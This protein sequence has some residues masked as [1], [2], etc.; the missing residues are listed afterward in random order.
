MQR[1]K[2]EIKKLKKNKKSEKKWMKSLESIGKWMKGKR[3]DIKKED[4]WERKIKKSLK[5]KRKK[6]WE[7]W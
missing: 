3:W 5:E 2:K 7:K 1:N 6:S 4:I